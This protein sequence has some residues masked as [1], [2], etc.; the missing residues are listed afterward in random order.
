MQLFIKTCVETVNLTGMLIL[1]GFLLGVFRNYS[2]MNFQRSIGNKAVM[3]TGFIG[4]PVHELSHAIAVL[5]FG[6][7][8]TAIKLFQKPGAGGVMGYVEHSYN[9][10]S[11][12][13]QVGNFFIGIAPIFGGIACMIA[14]MHVTIPQTYDNFI[15][16]LM[17]N[18]HVEVI[19][20]STIT[21]ILHSYFGLVKNIFSAENFQNPYFYVFLFISICISS[22]I[23]LSMAD[24]KGASMGLTAIF[25]ILLILNIFG[26]S[27]YIQQ[28]NLIKYN[29][30]ITGFLVVAVIFSLITFIISLFFRIIKS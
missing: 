7:R 11:I 1:A 16:I 9:Q 5:L 20:S 18:I 25:F 24:I 6:H 2:L 15:N 3:I 17:K 4:V 8:I 23:S 12:Y 29:I 14:L 22:H 10:N 28:M 13:Q 27:K 26:L 30:M 21:G 19:D